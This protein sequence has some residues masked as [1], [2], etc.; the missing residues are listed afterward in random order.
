MTMLHAALHKQPVVLPGAARLR[1]QLVC[2]AASLLTAA[3]LWLAYFPV[4]CGW[5]AWFAPA[6]W[7]LLVRA[8][9]P[10]G[11]RYVFAWLGGMAFFVAALSWMRA[12]GPGMDY[13]W[14]LLALYCSWFWVAAL[15]LIRRLDRRTGLPLTITVPLVWTGLDFARGELMGGFAFY[16]LGQTQHAVLPAIQ[17]ADVAGV[18]AVTFLVAMVNGLLAEALGRLA[19]VRRWFGLPSSENQ[20][21]LRP[22]AIAVATLVVLVLGYGGWRIHQSEFAAGPRVALLQTKIDQVIR[23]A[24]DAEAVQRAL[25][26]QTGTL[27]LQAVESQRPDLVVW[28]E[29]TF[30]YDWLEVADGATLGT[31]MANW[32]SSRVDFQQRARRVAST[33][34]TNVLLVFNALV[35]GEHGR[36]RRYNSALLV[37]PGDGLVVRY[38]KIHL[39][40]FGEFLPFKD[41]L[42][43]MKAL[44]PYD[45]DYSLAVGEAQTRFRLTAGGKEYHFGVVICYEDSDA[46]LARRLV[47]PGA[48]PPVDFLVNIS[49]DGWFMGTA[50]HAEHLAVSRFRAVEARRAVLRAVNGGISAVIDGN[51]GIVALPGPTWAA[52]QSVSGLIS[53]AVPLDTRTSLYARLGDWLPWSCWGVLLVGCWWRPRTTPIP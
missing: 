30:P 11:R 20:S 5:L 27:S 26:E 8:E 34:G 2:I 10:R 31:D 16:L 28:P 33:L 36:I 14:V 43:F 38:D 46:A 52:S 18:A 51:G 35:Y 22:Q 23:N 4:S 7:L 29:T 45:Y 37:P 25:A 17:I 32:S 53:A 40:P 41:S 48:D 49:N 3:L 47:R 1:T 9:L 44:S 12:G 24:A 13:L 39:V 6:P 15:W 21:G 50:E 19:A 42:P